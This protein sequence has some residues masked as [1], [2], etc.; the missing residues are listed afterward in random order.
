MSQ[1]KLPTIDQTAELFAAQFREPIHLPFRF[2][3][4]NGG[5]ILLVHGFPGTP[6]EMRPLAESFAQAGWTAEGMLLPG[7]GKDIATLPKR[8]Q[9][10]WAEAV[11]SALFD[12][13]AHHAPVIV[14]GNSMGGA[15]TVGAVSRAKADG[16]ILINP[17]W[18]IENALWNM[19]PVLKYVIPQF[20]PFSLVKVDFN[21]PETRTGMKNF[22]PDA[23]LD[24]PQ[25]QK[26]IKDFAIPT[27]MLDQIRVAGKIAGEVAPNV[28]I[29]ILIIQGAGDQLV[30]P[31][32]TRAFAAK[33]P[34][35]D[36][37]ELPGAHD[38]LASHV[39]AFPNVERLALD[40]AAARLNR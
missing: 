20:K 32:T 29:P 27:G 2:D 8:T 38:L 13:M 18:K 22:M 30:N 12:L 23:D 5:A 33:F 28:Q 39:P 34:R 31:A 7:F 37:H 15:L 11:D 10:E 9:G 40:F 6:A 4:T 24:D 36:M 19:L 21:N 35:A 26:A 17:F 1:N 16:A 3:G 25:V 14:V